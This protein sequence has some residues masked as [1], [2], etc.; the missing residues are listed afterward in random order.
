M[1]QRNNI[2]ILC[3]QTHLTPTLMA[4][5][6][7]LFKDI[8]K[9]LINE[10]NTYSFMERSRLMVLC[11]MIYS[12][13]VAQ[14]C[15]IQKIGEQ[16]SKVNGKDSETGVKQVKR[17][18]KSEYSDYELHFSTCGGILWNQP[19]PSDRLQSYSLRALKKFAIQ[20]QPHIRFGVEIGPS[21]IHFRTAFSDDT[22][23]GGWFGIGH[24]IVHKKM[25]KNSLGLSMRAKVE[26]PFARGFGTELAI[27]SN[28][29]K[30][31][32][33]IGVEVLILTGWVRNRL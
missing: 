2:V 11:N 8:K 24:D 9:T 19:T 21:L 26:M 30:H 15:G 31:Q 33:Y 3:S 18:L 20:S 22:Y 6:R 7:T 13:L 12:C 27:V 17:G 14:N 32:N 28:I 10:K 16:V 1:K 4:V 23:K 29:N 25:V 5:S